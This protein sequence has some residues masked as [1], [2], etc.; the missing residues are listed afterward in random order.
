MMKIKVLRDEIKNIDLKINEIT[1]INYGLVV[2]NNNETY[3]D[4]YLR[5]DKLLSED[6]KKNY[7]LL[8][9]DRRK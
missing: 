4:L 6:K 1:G 3:Q 8:G 5:A 2:R 7:K 9:I